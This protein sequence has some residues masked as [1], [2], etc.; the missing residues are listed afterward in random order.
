[1]QPGDNRFQHT[2]GDGQ[3]F[4]RDAGAKLRVKARVDIPDFQ[5]T[6]DSEPRMQ[7]AAQHAI[8]GSKNLL[9]RHTCHWLTGFELIADFM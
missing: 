9:P 4:I 3:G 6:P 1:M 8:K 5:T 7:E 2:A